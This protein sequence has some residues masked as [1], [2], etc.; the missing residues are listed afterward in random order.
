MSTLTMAQTVDIGH[1]RGRLA[2]AA[3]RSLSRIDAQLGRPLDVNSAWRDPEQQDRMHEAWVAYLNGGP[4]PNHGRALPSWSSVHCKGR[5]IDTDDTALERILNDHGWFRTAS[6]EPWHYEYFEHRDNHRNE[7]A[8]GG[9]RPFDPITEQ[10][11]Y[12]MEPLY[13]RTSPKASVWMINP[14]T[15]T[16]REVTT[17]EWEAAKLRGAHTKVAT[18]TE[19][20]LAAVKVG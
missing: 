5:A 13:V 17:A 20:Q 10:E 15:G 18:V 16:R 9:V 2:P 12:D 6:D 1:G 11:Y 8:G 14:I 3:A 19:A 7:P 4:R